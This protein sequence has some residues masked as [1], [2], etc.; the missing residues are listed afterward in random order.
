MHTQA[1]GQ[2]ANSMAIYKNR[3]VAVGNNLQNDP[4]FKRYAKLDLKG[5]AVIPGLVDAHTHFYYFALSFR[6]ISL[7]GLD[8][9]EKCL[10]KINNFSS[11]L[12][13]NEWVLGEGYAPDRFKKRIEPDRYMLDKV[14]S[15][16]P[17]FIFSKDQHTAWVNSRA[18]KQ[19]GLD[20]KT[21][22]PTGGRIERLPG[23]QPSGILR[24]SAAY[25][26]VLD[27]IPKPSPRVV[28][29]CYR[30]ALDYAYRKGVTGVHSVDSP[31]AF[32]YFTD[33]ARRGKLGLRIDYYM[34]CQ[35]LP[36]L[37]EEK[38][39]YGRG[40]SF[41]R[42][43]GIKIFSDGALGSQTA[44]CFNKYIGS[45]NNYGVEV[46]TVKQLE[47]LIKQAAKL[48]LPCAIH[49]I[50]DRAVSNVLDALEASP[51]PSFGARH[52]IEHLQLIQRKDIAR[53]K[54]MN[55]V[56]SMQPSHCPSD[57]E[58]IRKYWGARGSNAYIFKTLIDACVPLAF[59]SDC[60]IEPLDP[61][62]G[63]AAAV[64][65]AR[66]GKRD[67]FY[68]KQ[69]ITAAQA[70]YN[71]TAGAAYAAGM[72]HTRGCLLPGYLADYVILSEDPTLVAPS[73]LGDIQ[74]LATYLDGK[75]KY[76]HPSFKY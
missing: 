72:E 69:R 32:T 7:D 2:I 70:L 1:D 17:A 52:R 43:A 45:K 57:I 23:G 30:K 63:I 75:Q 62:G 40:N 8:S 27:L 24:E 13:K 36:E 76:A 44:L 74:V 58:M 34:T 3:I 73:K 21:A 33:L 12:K 19:A 61:L 29:Q 41:F 5:H 10:D 4:S 9:L 31:E 25:D 18:L 67:I 66:Q 15:G 39:Y 16:R 11:G 20:K 71:F 60:P 14:T 50:G 37:L 68:P 22:E 28:D 42:L 55:I 65:R 35:K 47:K 53:L 38:V 51:R 6:R 46:M 59:G 48:G 64:R 56:A 26:R 54:K 49:A